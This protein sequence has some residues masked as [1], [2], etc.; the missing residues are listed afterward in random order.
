MNPPLGPLRKW[1]LIGLAALVCLFGLVVGCSDDKKGPKSQPEAKPAPSAAA[2]AQ[3]TASPPTTPDD[4]PL[5]LV[6]ALSAFAERDAGAEGLPVPLPAELEFIARRGGEWVK[7]TLSD[8]ESNV[9][10]KALAYTTAD[11]SMALLTGAGSK[12]IVKLWKKEAGQFVSETLWEKDFGGRFSRIRDI[13]VGDVDGDG[14]NVIVVATHDQGVVAIIRPSNG[15]YEV[16]EL[17]SEKD[18]FVHEIELGDMDADGA[19]EIYATPSEPNRLDGSVQSGRVVRYQPSKGEGRVVVADLGERHAKEILVH[20]IDGDGKD[21]LYVLVEGQKNPEGSGLLHRTEIWRFDLDTK[22]DQGVVIAELDDR[23]GRFL[24]P[25]DLDG[26]GEKE[27]VVALFQKGV[28][29]LRPN[30]DPMKPW[31]KKAIDRRSSSFEHAVIATDLDGDG[32]Q[33]LYVV[34]DNDKALRRYVWNGRRFIKEEIYKRGDNRSILT[35]NI[36]PIPVELV[37]D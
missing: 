5:A 25:S 20:D 35:W 29:W 19:I 33:E 14:T 12:A 3:A 17:D 18:T 4:L 34:S 28:W 21:E 15:G 8:P 13:E 32:V 31:R 10:H 23:L 6:L 1:G 22:P 36:M 7:T 26:N 27:I 30:A 2:T 9:F 11:G 16:E 37:A 24:T